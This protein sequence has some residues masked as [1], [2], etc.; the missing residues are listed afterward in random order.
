MRDMQII[1]YVINLITILVLHT[2]TFISKEHLKVR[3]TKDKSY[4]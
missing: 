4:M 2:F 3:Y 1:I